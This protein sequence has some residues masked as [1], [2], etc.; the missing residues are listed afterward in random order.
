MVILV[1]M[2]SFFLLQLPPGDYVTNLTMQLRAQGDLGAMERA[3]ALRERYGLDQPVHIQYFRWAGALLQGDLG[4]S[5]MHNMPVNELLGDRMW[6]TIGAALLTL[7]ISWGLA[8]PIGIYSATHKY[9]V[10]DYVL[11]FVAFVGIAIP[12]FMLAMVLMFISVFYLGAS[13][14]GGLFSTEY[15]AA[16]WSFGK[17]ID[18]LKHL[19]IPIIV[20]GLGGMAGTMRIMR[21]N[22]MDVLDQQYVQTARAKGLKERDVVLKHAVPVAINPLISRL[23]LFLPELISGAVIISVVL[24][25]PTVGPIFLRALLE[26]DMQLAGAIV[27]LL[28][29][30]LVIGN[31]LADILLA[32]VDPRIR[33]G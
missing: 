1:S 21:G 22:L 7:V 33:L 13:T 20:L 32:V 5:M 11:S 8:I 9:R 30:T 17:F 28:A 29:I 18:L 24:N 23:G 26:Q 2:V 4:Y 27:F 31:L 6:L 14:V 12:N 3:E 10:S 15:M 25:L 16:P 19:P